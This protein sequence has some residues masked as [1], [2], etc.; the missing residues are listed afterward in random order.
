MSISDFE[1][2]KTLFFWFLTACI[3]SFCLFMIFLGHDTERAWL[4][5]KGDIYILEDINRKETVLTDCQYDII[6]KRHLSREAKREFK[7]NG[8]V[9]FTVTNKTFSPCNLD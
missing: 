3:I 6:F 7:E 5:K 4:I 1:K 8:V 2:D 9:G